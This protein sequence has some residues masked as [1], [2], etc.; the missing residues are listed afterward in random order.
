MNDSFMLPVGLLTHALRW[1]LVRFVYPVHQQ[2]S[3]KA[4]LFRRTDH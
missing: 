4:K 2:A 1:R 3:L